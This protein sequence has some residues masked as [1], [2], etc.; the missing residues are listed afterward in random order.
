MGR[1]C[2]NCRKE[3]NDAR[4]AFCPAC[5]SQ[6]EAGRG[7]QGMEGLSFIDPSGG[8]PFHGPESTTLDAWDNEPLRCKP[9]TFG[10]YGYQYKVHGTLTHQ[11]QKMSG[12]LKL[13]IT[14]IE[15]L[16]KKTPI[17]VHYASIT[18]TEQLASNEFTVTTNDGAVYEYKAVN[19]KAWLEK[20]DSMR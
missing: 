17:R 13:T 20:I 5:G 3:I 18:R 7:E 8:Q 15:F 2:Q 9:F 4:V 1:S 19:A 16:H 12:D 14:G 10:P 11:G 6:L